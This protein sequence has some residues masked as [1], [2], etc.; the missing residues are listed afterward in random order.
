M[1]VDLAWIFLILHFACVERLRGVPQDFMHWP[2]CKSMF[3]INRKKIC[4]QSTE[5]STFE[6]HSVELVV[7]VRDIYKLPILS[8]VSN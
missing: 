8:N 4:Y 3:Y 1:C 5:L 6:L 2:K 7:E